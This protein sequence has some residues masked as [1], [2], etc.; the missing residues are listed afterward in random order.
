[1]FPGETD[2]TRIDIA[3]R[4]EG[5]IARR[6]VARGDNVAKGQLLFEIDNPELLTGER[7]FKA[8][9]RRP[10]PNAPTHAE[11]S[12]NRGPRSGYLRA[13]RRQRG[14]RY[15]LHNLG[16]YVKRCED[17]HFPRPSR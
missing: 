15:D 10:D 6:A 13:A 16:S 4:V 3:A 8:Q 1:M 14:R 17:L 5:R 2:A 11:G 7:R 9:D 12:G